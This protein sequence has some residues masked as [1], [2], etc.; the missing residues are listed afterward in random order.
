[1]HCIHCGALLPEGAKFCTACGQP[2][3]VVPAA[4]DPTPV[5]EETPVP[6]EPVEEVAQETVEADPAPVNASEGYKAANAQLPASYSNP[7]YSYQPN[8]ASNAPKPVT[9]G[10]AIAGFVCSLILVPVGIGALCA[11][12]G[13]V[14]SIMGLN[15]AKKLP[16]RKGYGLSVA[17]IILC[18]IH[19]AVVLIIVVA[20]FTAMLRGLGELGRELINNWPQYMPYTY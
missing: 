18:S 4:A 7:N 10:L 15:N 12:A 6:A 13:L 11:I 5:V 2:V 16:D 19:L 14:L 17:G 8:L 9:N 3:Q 20:A 1:M